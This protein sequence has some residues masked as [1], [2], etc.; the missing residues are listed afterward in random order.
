MFLHPQNYTF[1]YNLPY[2]NHTFSMFLGMKITLF[3]FWG[4]EG[5]KKK[6]P[7]RFFYA[8]ALFMPGRFFRGEAGGLLET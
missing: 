3:P 4:G 6:R 5:H 7:G 1:S 2:Q 8:G